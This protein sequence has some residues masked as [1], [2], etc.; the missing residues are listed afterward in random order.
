MKGFEKQRR[1][2]V[3]Y[4]DRLINENDKLGSVLADN[5][6]MALPAIALDGHIA[7]STA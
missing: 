2:P 5:L 3:E 4:K 1:L 7:L 6:Q